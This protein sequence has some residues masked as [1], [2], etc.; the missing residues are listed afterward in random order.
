VEIFVALLGLA[1]GITGLLAA[2]LSRRQEVVH[3]HETF[4]EPAH[5]PASHAARRAGPGAVALHSTLVGFA[6]GTFFGVIVL[7]GFLLAA[8][9]KVEPEQEMFRAVGVTGLVLCGIIGTA[10]GLRTGMRLA[11]LTAREERQETYR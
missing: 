9:G 11:E 2:V 7:S 5:S 3:R 1:G 6:I 8:K 10:V 4:G